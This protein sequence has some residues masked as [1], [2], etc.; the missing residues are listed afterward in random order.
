[1]PGDSDDKAVVYT[2]VT[3]RI[4]AV[5]VRI[6]MVTNEAKDGSLTAS[7]AAH[8][9]PASLE[10]VAAKMTAMNSKLDELRDLME[11]AI[12]LKPDQEAYIMEKQ[13]DYTSKV[14]IAS[15]ILQAAMANAAKALEAEKAASKVEASAPQN[16]EKTMPCSIDQK[17]YS[18]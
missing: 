15:K 14:S 9:T 1:M 18:D 3:N 12:A 6:T 10:L 16:Q 8:P 7:L 4:K 2:E 5:K 17:F 11:Q 13:A